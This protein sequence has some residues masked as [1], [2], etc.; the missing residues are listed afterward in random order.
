MA[1]ITL[2]LPVGYVRLSGNLLR[3]ADSTPKEDLFV[4]MIEGGNRV[5][6]RLYQEYLDSLRRQ[7]VS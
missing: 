6:R 2:A 3:H 5:D 1:E 7:P 4:F